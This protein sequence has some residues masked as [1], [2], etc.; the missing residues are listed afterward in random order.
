MVRRCSEWQIL[1][2]VQ[3]RSSADLRFGVVEPRSRRD[4]GGRFTSPHP[5]PPGPLTA[6]ADIGLHVL[7][8]VQGHVCTSGQNGPKN[9]NDCGAPCIELFQAPCAILPAGAQKGLTFTLKRAEGSL[10]GE[11]CLQDVQTAL[12]TSANRWCANLYTYIGLMP[13]S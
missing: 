5:P 2:M 10:H 11:G 7:Q 9:E 3:F 8:N 6:V 4:C 13:M 1:V 12:C